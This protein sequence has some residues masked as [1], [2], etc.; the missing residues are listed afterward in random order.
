[1]VKSFVKKVDIFLSKKSKNT[2]HKT[3]NVKGL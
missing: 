1:M 2:K 3:L